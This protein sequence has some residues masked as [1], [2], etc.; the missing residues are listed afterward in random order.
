MDTSTNISLDKEQLLEAI[1]EAQAS[2][3]NDKDTRH[4]F[5][6]LLISLLKLT[7][8]EYGYIGEVLYQPD[9]NPF[10]RTHA[11]SNIAW[12]DDTRKFYEQHAPT[13]LEFYNLNTLFGY[14]LDKQEIVISNDPGNDPRAG[15]L[16]P[17]HPDLNAYLGLPFMADGKLVGSAGISNR[18]NG[19]DDELVEFLKPFMATCANIL[20]ANRA[21][22]EQKRNE[23][24]KSDFVSIVSH[25]L[26]TPMTAIR[27]SL[28]LLDGIY[29]EQLPD[30]AKEIITTANQ[31]C[32]RMLRLLDDILDVQRMETGTIE[33][34]PG[35][36]NL[37]NI[38][39]KVLDELDAQIKQAEV[40]VK[41]HIEDNLIIQ[42]DS[43]RMSQIIINLI[44]N[45]IKFTPK[46]ILTISAKDH[47]DRTTINIEDNGKGIPEEELPHIFDKFHQ[48]G[49]VN[50]RNNNGVGLGLFI[51]KKL[52]EKHGGTIEASSELDKGTCFTIN[53][54]KY[55]TK[56]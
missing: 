21:Q 10:L 33:I 40:Q 54:P 11:I 12:D 49:D 1:S 9:G 36:C 53:L 52:V 41:T 4:I 26:R 16:P 50:T 55:W 18:V 43:D 45:A 34:T 31:G 8:S 27:G 22:K 14:V 2:Y 51:V 6:S 46:G 38:I 15:G 3:I 7:G 28:G 35:K 42:A 25:E 37:K 48:I 32:I 24:I 29:K 39:I 47:G 19:Y 13:G 5:D 20:L 23:K 17:G 44:S 56:A 30:Q